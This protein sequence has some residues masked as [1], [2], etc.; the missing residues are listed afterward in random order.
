NSTTDVSIMSWNIQG[1]LCVKLYSPE[2]EDLIKENDI[3]VLQETH[4]LPDDEECLATP[5]GFYALSVCRKLTGSWERHGGGV[6]AFIRNG[7]QASKSPLSS[8]DILVLD[9]ITCWLVGAYILPERSRWQ[10]FTDVNPEHKLDETVALCA[11]ADE[12]KPILLFLDGNARTQSEKAGGDLARMSADQKPIS[13]RGSRLLST[14]RR[15]NLVILNGTHLEDASPGRFTSIKEAGVAEAVVDYA[16]VSDH[17]LSSVRS[18]SVAIPPEPTEAWSDHVSLTLR[19]DRKFLQVAPRLPKV[20]RAPPKMPVGDAAMDDLCTQVMASK[21]DATEMLRTLYGEVYFDTP[22][23]QVYVHGSC[24]DIGSHDAIGVG[25]IFWGEKSQLNRVDAVPGPDSPTSNR[26]ALYAVTMALRMA[27]PDISLM[28]FTNSEYCIRHL[29]YW[30]GKN[31]QIGWSCA[32]GD[33]LKDLVLL[34]RY[35]RAPTRFVRVERDSKNERAAAAKRSA[36]Q[37][38]K[39]GY[40]RA[41]PHCAVEV[42]PWKDSEVSGLPVID[43]PKVSTALPEIATQRQSALRLQDDDEEGLTGNPEH[44]RGRVKLRDLQKK[45]RDSI[46]ECKDAGAFWRIMRGW[47]DP[48]PKPIQVSLDQLT[49]EFTKRMNEPE[50]TPPSFNKEQLRAWA[51]LF[52]Q[53]PRTN[54]DH[55]P[56]K[57]FSRKLTLEDIQWGKRQIMTHL[58]TSSGIDDFAYQDIME[59]PNENLLILLQAV[60]DRKIFPSKWLLA[61]VAGILKPR[62]DPLRPESYRLVVLECCLLKFLTLLIDRRVKEFA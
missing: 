32:N 36:Q 6:T 17:L 12:T 38:L 5:K 13:P 2:F 30:A 52:E 19:I 47:T 53:M 43:V 48:R 9:L 42:N 40:S 50:E 54:R 16:V 15:S 46:F 45:L 1:N 25:A 33:L 7:I 41:P 24:K 29:C 20:V 55:S 51:R 26:A 8:P 21:Q 11:A 3:V 31:S 59:I 49:E 28:I 61:L 4:L 14:W 23:A 58:A 34:L 44:H 27:N 60:I 57:S 37:G 39:R 62:K 22:Y 10:Q 35:R 18:L 56:R